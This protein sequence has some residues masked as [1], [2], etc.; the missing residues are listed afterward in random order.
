MVTFMLIAISNS[1]VQWTVTMEPIVT[2]G[3]E[4]VRD[5]VTH[6]AGSKALP[7]EK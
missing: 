7:K 4:G 3:K 6:T 5:T 2:A 1:T